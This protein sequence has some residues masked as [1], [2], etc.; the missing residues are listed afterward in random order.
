[1]DIEK[2]KRDRDRMPCREKSRGGQYEGREREG[3][4]RGKEIGTERERDYIW[5]EMSC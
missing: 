1:M 3:R 4:W 5:K 2:D